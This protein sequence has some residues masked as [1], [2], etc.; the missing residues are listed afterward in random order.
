MNSRTVWFVLAAVAL[1]GVLS[2]SFGVSSGVAERQV[3]IAVADEPANAFVGINASDEV[4]GTNATAV[5]VRNN[6]DGD[7]I[8]E[9]ES[10]G[11]PDCIESFNQT[12]EIEPGETADI[13]VD[14]NGS[15]GT[16]TITL[17]VT[18]PND[19]FTVDTSRTIR[20]IAG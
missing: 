8:V 2:G 15:D 16:F 13:T 9:A 6:L 4:H 7:L 19:R 20:C 5:T 18:S 17:D 12:A 11:Q 14:V 3:D 10:E 1:A